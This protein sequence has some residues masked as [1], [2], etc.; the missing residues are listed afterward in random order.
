MLNL[1]QLRGKKKKKKEKGAKLQKLIL[2]NT[3]KPVNLSNC[4]HLPPS[5][6]HIL[7]LNAKLK[8]QQSAP[9]SRGNIWISASSLD[10]HHFAL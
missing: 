5:T 7:T 1:P 8:T 3:Y 2:R 9:L 4:F 10:Y 6:T